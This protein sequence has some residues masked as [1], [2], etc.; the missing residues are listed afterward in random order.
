MSFGQ[1]FC[2]AVDGNQLPAEELA[3]FERYDRMG[4]Q[5]KENALWATVQQIAGIHPN[6]SS[7]SSAGGGR[8][9]RQTIRLHLFEPFILSPFQFAPTVSS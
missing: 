3:R 4:R 6:N 7:S 9:K 2:A 1:L 5:E 8:A